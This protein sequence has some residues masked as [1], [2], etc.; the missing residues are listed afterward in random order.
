M[1]LLIKTKEDKKLYFVTIL[2][3][4]SLTRQ[5][6]KRK[7]FTDFPSLVRYKNFLKIYYIFARVSRKERKKLANIYQSDNHWKMKEFLQKKKKRNCSVL[8]G[9]LK[10]KVLLKSMQ[11]NAKI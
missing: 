9:I 5:L 11:K 3:D 7:E 8:N 2:K 1:F 4:A 10:M 6:E